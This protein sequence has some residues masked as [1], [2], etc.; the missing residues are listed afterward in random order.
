[1]HLTH[2]QKLL[3]LVMQS[4]LAVFSYQFHD[5]CILNLLTLLSLRIE[6]AGKTQVNAVA[7]D[8]VDTCIARPSTAIIS[9]I[10][11]GFQLAAPSHTSTRATLNTEIPSAA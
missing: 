8:A 1:M 9:I 10:S 2:F 5:L 3:D 11:L 4:I 7:A 6:K